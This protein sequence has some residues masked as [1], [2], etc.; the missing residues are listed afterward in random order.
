MKAKILIAEDSLTIQRVFELAFLRS[1]YQVTY[2]DRGED[3]KG[4]AREL[5]PEL[6]I[7]DLTLPDVDGYEAV[8]ELK[9]EQSLSSIPIILLAGSIEPFD[10]D[11]FR[12][13][14]ADGVIFKPFDSQELL[15]KVGELLRD[16][17]EAA[18][19]EKTERREAVEEGWDFSDVFEEVELDGAGVEKSP[20]EEPF[21]TE[22]ITES[23]LPDVESFEDYDIGEDE[24]GKEEFF[25]EKPLDEV[26]AAGD[27]EERDEEAREYE[28]DEVMGGLEMEVQQELS[29][30]GEV[31]ME[32]G[33]ER[34]APVEDFA[35]LSDADPYVREAAENDDGEKPLPEPVSPGGEEEE[36]TK[37]DEEDKMM[38]EIVRDVDEF[39]ISSGYDLEA[40]GILKKAA[41]QKAEPIGSREK[42]EE[43]LREA[44][45]SDEFSGELKNLVSGTTE[46]ILW[47]VL[48]EIME[49]LKSEI[50]SV[51][52]EVSAS[53]VPEVAGQIIQEEI[54]RIRE[55][56]EHTD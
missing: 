8:S 53:V 24:L 12:S 51:I 38:E 7:C 40:H 32:A 1:G 11:L 37:M 44:F 28:F 4:M 9:K 48:P 55:E 39:P 33:E 34:M 6:I 21:V 45:S 19:E 31:V 47:E 46:K 35:D 23:D 43:K 3:L 26:R 49:N 22:L 15:D 29:G 56:I 18:E 41:P 14:G 13:S 10:E 20:S 36:V 52:K 30:E 16:K 17:V 50:I 42:Y 5:N 25:E 54:K 27:E 2:I